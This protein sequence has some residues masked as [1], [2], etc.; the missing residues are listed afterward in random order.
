MP[1]MIQIEHEVIIITATPQ[2]AQ[3]EQESEVIAQVVMPEQKETKE[4]INDFRA[5]IRSYQVKKDEQE[6]DLI[7]ICMSEVRSGKGEF[8]LRKDFHDQ[9][10][11]PVIESTFEQ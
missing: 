3:I 4:K 2:T 8:S 5:F 1:Q 7:M 11:Y 9:A 6:S 10:V